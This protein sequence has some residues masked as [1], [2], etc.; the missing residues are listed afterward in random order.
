MGE[1]A[2]GAVRITPREIYDAVQA[3]DRKV[4]RIATTLESY[5]DVQR[6]AYDAHHQ[7][8]S[9]AVAIGELKDTL[10]WGVRTV[11]GAIITALVSVLFGLASLVTVLRSAARGG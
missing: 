10:R 8:G 5:P 7:S 9:N 6:I 3:L 1:S 11:F 2:N 4:D